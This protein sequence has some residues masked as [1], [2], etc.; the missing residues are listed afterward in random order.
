MSKKVST[1]FS[2]IVLF[3]LVLSACAAP[4]TPTEAPVATEAPATEPPTPEPTELPATAEATEPPA[5]EFPE[6]VT[7][8]ITITLPQD[9]TWSDGTALTSKDL[10]GTW[11]IL[12]MRKSATWDSLADVVAKDDFTVQFLIT[13]PGPAVLDAIVRSNSPRPYSQYGQ[14]MDAAAQF[15][16][17]NADRDGAE[18]AAV[19]E[20]LNAFT[21][22]EGVVY[23]PY[24]IDPASVS[25]A[26]L[27]LVKVPSGFNADKIDFDS[28]V[29]FWG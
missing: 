6:G 26:Q 2:L 16:A 17:D 29:V 15:R 27:S 8:V 7:A 12:W 13:T 1:I 5:E 23:G 21:P 28:V 9:A 10:V 4:P 11:D 20:E 24:N 14:W 18:V 19:N 22:E 25:E 3:A